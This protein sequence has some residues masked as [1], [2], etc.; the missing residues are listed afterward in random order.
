MLKSN[1]NYPYRAPIKTSR[2]QIEFFK[3][4]L[5]LTSSKNP[6]GA[7]A[8]ATRQR[9]HQVLLYRAASNS[10]RC[11]LWQLQQPPPR[12]KPRPR[13]RRRWHRQL[14]VHTRAEG[15]TE[16]DKQQVKVQWTHVNLTCDSSWA[17][18][19]LSHTVTSSCKS[20]G[21]PARPWQGL[22]Q[23]STETRCSHRR[24]TSN[25]RDWALAIRSGGCACCQHEYAKT[26]NCSRAM[27]YLVPKTKTVPV[28]V[29]ESL[30]S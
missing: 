14:L 1:L 22:A 10:T 4:L 7:A 6:N 29:A 18:M 3:L 9:M 16:E 8:S 30:H 15:N 25:A 28:K 24:R 17:S 21:Q 11:R 13:R 23:V 5:H 12:L 2:I 27:K 19:S 26:R 20:T